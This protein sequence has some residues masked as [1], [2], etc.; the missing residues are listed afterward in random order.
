MAQRYSDPFEAG[1]F[2]H[3][4]NR[5]V[6]NDLLFYQKK[7]YDYFLEK[8][9]ELV[10]DCL[11]IYAYCLL[12]NHFHFLI[13]IPEAITD[14]G[15]VSEKFRRLFLGYSQAI[16]K[17]QARKGTLL[18]R[19]FKRKKVYNDDYLTALIGYIHLNP[20]HHNLANNFRNYPWSSYSILV[21]DTATNLKREEIMNWFGSKEAFIRYHEKEMPTKRHKRKHLTLEE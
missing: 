4:Y 10:D 12:P 2:Y 13:F 20:V 7:N 1:H 3:L 5:A 15:I 14:T 21:S 11:D 8:F 16:N 17:Q 9:H 18:M 6:G 19:P